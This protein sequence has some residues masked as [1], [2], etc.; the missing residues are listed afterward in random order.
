MTPLSRSPAVLARAITKSSTG[1]A[2][3]IS[4]MRLITV[5]VHAAVEA[6]EGAHQDADDH[7]QQRRADGDLERGLGAVEQAQEL[8][9]AE[10]AVRAE[11]EEGVLEMLPAPPAPD[12]AA[13]TPRVSGPTGSTV[14]GSSPPANWSLGP[15]PR[16]CAA[17]GAPMNP[18]RTSRTM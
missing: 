8:V 7:G 5:S 6:G 12:R 13:S 14:C 15:W 1:K 16:K 2:I 11:D 9:A 17:I 10:L 3:T 18:T 4:V